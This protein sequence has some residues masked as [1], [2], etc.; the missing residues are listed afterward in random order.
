M[1]GARSVFFCNYSVGPQAYS[2]VPEVCRPF[3]TKALLIGGQRA[4][5]IGRIGATETVVNVTSLKCSAGD[6]AFGSIMEI[7]FIFSHRG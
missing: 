6:A 4:R 1:S 7:T 2:L 5:V 3:G